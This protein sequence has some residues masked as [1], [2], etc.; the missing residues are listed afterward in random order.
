MLFVGRFFC[1]F[2]R[3]KRE[4]MLG[5]CS[6]GKIRRVTN[7]IQPPAVKAFRFTNAPHQYGTAI[8]CCMV[9]MILPPDTED[10]VAVK[11]I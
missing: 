1:L 11:R 6:G 5:Q 2:F 10:A 7:L 4:K 8:P 3:V 9:A